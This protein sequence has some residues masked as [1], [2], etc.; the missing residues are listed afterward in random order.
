MGVL[1]GLEVGR[2]VDQ[3]RDDDMMMVFSWMI[4]LVDV[5]VLRVESLRDGAA[6]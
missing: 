5:D 4:I 3:G 2:G 6:E 1:L